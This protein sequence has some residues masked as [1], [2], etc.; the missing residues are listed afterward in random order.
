MPTNLVDDRFEAP[1]PTGQVVGSASRGGHARLG[2]DTEHVLSVDGGALRVAPLIEAGWGR[3]TLAYGPL[4]FSPGV[5]LGVSVLDGHNTS[6]AEPLSERFGDRMRRWLR[7]PHQSPDLALRLARLRAFCSASRFDRLARQFLWWFRTDERTRTVPILNDNLAVGFFADPQAGAPS[8]CVGFTMQALG[9]QNGALAL[10]LGET[11]PTQVVRGV[12]NLPLLLAVVVRENS[13][14]YAAAS[15]AGAYGMGPG[16]PLLRPLGVGPLPQQAP[17]YVGVAQAVLGQIG[18]RADTRVMGVRVAQE[19]DLA[20][21][22]AGAVVAD[23]LR[24]EDGGGLPLAP[25]FVRTPHGAQANTE[26]ESWQALVTAAAPIGLLRVSLQTNEA[27]HAGAVGVVFRS[28]SQGFWLCGYDGAFVWLAWHARSKSAPEELARAAWPRGS[29]VLQ[30]LDDGVVMDVLLGGAPVFATST[31]DS[32]SADALGVG[33]WAA[34]ASRGFD[35]AD[36][37]AL[38]RALTVACLQDLPWPKTLRSQTLRLR[39]GFAGTGDLA[40]H[41]CEQG[42]CWRRALGEGRMQLRDEGGVKVVGSVQSPSPDRTIY[43]LPWLNPQLADLSV[44]IH[45]PGSGRAQGEKTRG[46][47]VFWQDNRNYMIV[48]VYLDDHYGGASISSFFQLEGYEDLYDAIWTNVG[49][50]F[51]W[52]QSFN[53]RVIFDGQTYQAFVNEEPVLF[54]RLSDVYANQAPLQIRRVGLVA[55]WEWGQDTGTVFEDFVGRG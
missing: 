29:G 32:R 23:R 51:S 42:L 17:A 28:G 30:I 15:F 20:G 2:V 38:P 3:S 40:E 10:P 34:A 52:G 7:G 39:D 4:P 5:V 45:A 13:V 50:R 6:Q 24:D 25:G 36:F 53:L 48:S 46:G 27:N 31:K 11:T 37:E 47:L 35:L 21:W 14:L 1:V 41:R 16:W 19:P 9:P 33:V 43:T 54:R 49:D 44:R 22:A 12:Q 26:A 55:N 18:F 8:S